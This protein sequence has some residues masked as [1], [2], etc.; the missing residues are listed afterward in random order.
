MAI[1]DLLDSVKDIFVIGRGNSYLHG[2]QR[3]QEPRDAYADPQEY[4][5][6]PAQGQP[7]QQAYGQPYAQQPYQAQPYPQQQTP[8]QPQQQAYPQQEQWQQPNPQQPQVTQAANPYQ[9]PEPPAFQTQFSPEP[10]REP[11]RNRRSQQ[12]QETPQPQENVVPF[13]GAVQQQPQQ[14]APEAKPVDVYVVNVYNMVSCRQA[15]NML[16]KGHCTLVVTDQLIDKAEV[17]H[18]V[19]ILSGACFALNGSIIRLSAKVG[20]YVMAPA[21]MMVYMDQ[22]IAG[23]NQQLRTPQP[24]A[25]QPYQPPVAPPQAY[26]APDAAYPQQPQPQQQTAP[27]GYQPMPEE[28]QRAQYP[29][30]AQQPQ[31]SANP[32]GAYAPQAQAQ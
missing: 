19:D 23:A 5:P 4:A 32:Y 14:P 8:W 9:R 16:R 25:Q 10:V 21:G 12:H 28:Q 13:P 27:Y 24:Q 22:A 7:Y 30:Y 6:Q 1:R 11:Q 2:R 26:Q 20:F 29:Q 3:R 31:Q 18:Y 17:R 15:V